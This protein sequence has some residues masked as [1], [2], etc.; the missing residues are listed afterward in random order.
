MRINL[1][2]NTFKLCGLLIFSSLSVY[3]TLIFDA[4]IL[5]LIVIGILSMTI[6]YKHKTKIKKEDLIAGVILAILCIPSSFVVGI[7]VFLSYVASVSL[8]K[9]E[10]EKIFLFENE[11]KNNLLKTAICIFL[12][13]GVLSAINVWSALGNMSLNPNLQLNSI[14]AALRAGIFEEATFRMFF[15]AIC[16]WIVKSSNFTGMQNLLCYAIMIIP[17]AL[18]HFNQGINLVSILI[19]SIL[20]GLPFAIMQRKQ[21]LISA[22]GSHFLVDLIRFFLLGA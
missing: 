2:N 13:G 18:L 1:K 7:F 11:K 8:F 19:I 6:I 5:L 15:F 10:E 12:I 14:F 21:N 22:I 20:F 16:I 4:I 9:V 3:L 17:H